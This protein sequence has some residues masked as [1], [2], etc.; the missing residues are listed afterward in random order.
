MSDFRTIVLAMAQDRPHMRAGT[1]VSLAVAIENAQPPE[2]DDAE[3]FAKWAAR[4]PEVM[5]YVR[6]DKKIHAIK[7]IRALTGASLLQA[8][9]AADRLTGWGQS[10]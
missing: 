6:A 9:N 5:Q 8:K 7:E 3:G 10:A 4:Q 1:L 2:L